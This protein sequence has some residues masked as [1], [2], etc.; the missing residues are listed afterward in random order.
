LNNNNDCQK[1]ENL[2]QSLNHSI[3]HSWLSSRLLQN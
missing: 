1:E 3:N 2:N